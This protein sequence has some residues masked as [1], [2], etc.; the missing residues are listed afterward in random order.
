MDKE[1]KFTCTMN[2]ETKE[3]RASVEPE[4]SSM[5]DITFHVSNVVNGSVV[6]L[7]NLLSCI[8]TVREVTA[9]EQELKTYIFTSEADRKLIEYRKRVCE[10]LR[11]IFNSLLDDVFV[12]VMYI[13]TC[14][15]YYETFAFEND[16]EAVEDYCKQIEELRIKIL[17]DLIE[18][19]KKEL[20]DT[21]GKKDD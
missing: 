12:D 4:P 11:K 15:S 9:E 14:K 21:N 19:A 6:V 13:D 18:K 10:D 5:D 20:S 3:S 8:P 7:Q 16:E 2:T 1:I 17:D